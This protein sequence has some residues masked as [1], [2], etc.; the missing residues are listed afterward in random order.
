MKSRRA[1]FL[2]SIAS[3]AL[4]VSGLA[5]NRPDKPVVAVLPSPA[6]S[7]SP[8]PS[9][10]P[11]DTVDHFIS[12]VF[13]P[14]Y[15]WERGALTRAWKKV[16]HHSNYELV[17]CVDGEVAGAY[18]GAMM[19]LDKSLPGPNQSSLIVFIKHAHNKYDLYWIF[20]EENL[21]RVSISRSS[22]SIMV[23]GLREDGSPVN[24]H[25]AWS[26]KDNKWTCIGL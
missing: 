19:I 25:I 11:N 23:G 15:D 18:G 3:L 1:Y 2:L 12:D 20:K 24:C 7:P 8:T 5:C 10:K 14:L 9:P 6:P 26:Q 21:S 4:L 22:G 16:P 17:R 13:D